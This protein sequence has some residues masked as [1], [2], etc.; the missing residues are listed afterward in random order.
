MDPLD[1]RVVEGLNAALGLMSQGSLC[2]AR[3]ALNGISLPESSPLSEVMARMLVLGDRLMLDLASKES[4]LAAVQTAMWE[5]E[6]SRERVRESEARMRTTLAS[7]G[8]GLV[9]TDAHGCVDY[10]NPVA[11]RL[12]GWGSAEAEG[13]SV[14][15]IF[16]IINA[17]TRLAVENPTARALQEGIVVGLANDTVLVARDGTERQIADSCAP[18]R[19]AEGRL[20]GAVLVFRDVTEEYSRREQ[21]RESEE[22]HRI[23]FVGSRDAMMTLEPP[24]WKFGSGNPA[25]W[26][27]F[28][29]DSEAEFT[30]LGP[31]DVSPERQPDGA[32]SS[33]KARAAIEL[34]LQEGSNFFPWTHKRVN[35]AEF[36]ANV[37]LTRIA[38]G[39][40]TILQAT[41]RDI[42]IQQRLEAELGQARKLEAVGQLAAGIAHEINTP[43]QFI[44]DSVHF[45]E[46]SFNDALQLVARYRRAIAALPSSAE[47]EALRSEAAEAEQ[48]ADLEFVREHAPAAFAR[49][50]DG[51][52]RIATIVSAMK[53]FAHPD[54]SAKSPADINRALQTTMTIAR[55]EYKY[56]AEL[57]AQFGELPAVPCHLG[58]L[59]QVF[60]N[61]IVNA[62]HAIASVVGTTESKGRIRIQ[63][64]REG[65]NIR[66]DISDTGCGIPEQVR[67]RVFD[68]FFTTKEVGRGSGQGLAIARAIVVNKHGGEISFQSEVG[69]GTT[70]SIL[71]PIDA[72]A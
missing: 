61:L 5:V 36:S 49:A 37:L 14:G 53:E 48:E 18:I 59:N 2:D 63:T 9:S 6:A 70:F 11:E 39:G 47:H 64:A 24:S 66:I 16:R 43:A 67:D 40:N 52:S 29:V 45:L 1:L 42:S 56:V 44:G 28:G 7:I 65:N 13:R 20:L 33:E 17:R 23:L 31:A 60:L 30:A 19:D 35:G 46:E 69:K 51:V 4:A 27:L 12:T 50:L 3:D 21:L 26:E 72:E 58:E 22:R 68:P 41:V 38:F 32:L 55:S 10:L 34:A 57:E 71:L 15:E 8:D 25:A 54:Q 62:S